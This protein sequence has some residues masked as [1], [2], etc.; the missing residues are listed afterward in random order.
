M[1][2]FFRRNNMVVV[3]ELQ[4]VVVESITYDMGSDPIK[5]I[6]HPSV[7]KPYFLLLPRQEGWAHTNPPARARDGIAPPPLN[8]WHAS[9]WK[10]TGSTLGQLRNIWW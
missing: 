6:T 2:Q 5:L 8:T 4:T 7:A 9:G 10:R 3:P 1:V